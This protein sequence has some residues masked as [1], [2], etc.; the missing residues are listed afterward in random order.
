M[1]TVAMMGKTI[2]AGEPMRRSSRASV[3][4]KRGQFYAVGNLTDGDCRYKDEGKE[5]NAHTR[6]KTL[7]DI[8]EAQGSDRQK[9]SQ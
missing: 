5:C 1:I 3:I 6:L 7:L 9:G 2:M 4:S 8:D